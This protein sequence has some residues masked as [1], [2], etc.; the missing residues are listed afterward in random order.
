MSLYSNKD[1]TLVATGHILCGCACQMQALD[2]PSSPEDIKVLQLHFNQASRQPYQYNE[3]CLQ[4]D[5]SGCTWDMTIVAEE[6]C[7]HKQRD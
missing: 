3:A 6:F 4:H 5:G 7:K 2:N 1:Y